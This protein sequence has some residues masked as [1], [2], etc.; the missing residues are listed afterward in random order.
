MGYG[1][2]EG[3]IRG[4]VGLVGVEEYRGIV[5]DVLV[6]VLKKGE[7]GVRIMRAVVAA[8]LDK[9]FG[10]GWDGV[11]GVLDYVDGDVGGEVI[12]LVR[13]MYLVDVISYGLLV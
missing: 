5:G 10:G 8:V 6:N 3:A 9:G 11:V 12:G 7:D 4:C 1:W 2:D 13:D